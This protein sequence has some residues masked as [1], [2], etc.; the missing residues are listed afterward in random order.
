ME[1]NTIN[2]FFIFFFLGAI[3]FFYFNAERFFKSLKLAKP[4]NRTDHFWRRLWTTLKI[5]FG[6][7]RILR[8][9]N[10]GWLHVAIFW[11]FL[12][13]LFSASEALI[14]GFFPKFSWNFL[15]VF[16]S[17]ITLLT[18]IFAL[19]ILAAV[20]YAFWRRFGIKVKRLQGDKSEKIDATLVLGFIFIIVCS[21]LLQNTARSEYI[22]PPDYSIHPVSALLSSMIIFNP[23]QTF[24]YLFWFMHI[25]TI[26]IFANYLFYSKHFHVYTSIFNVFFG[27]ETIPNKLNPINFED[28]TIEQYGA[29]EFTDFTWKSLLDGY[30]CTHC[31]RC[32]SVCPAN[33]TGKILDPRRI[34]IGIRKRTDEL[35]PILI[36]QNESKNTN[37]T[38]LLPEEKSVL[39][40]KLIGDYISAEALWQCTTCGACMQECPLT[41]EHV[42]A[43]VEMRRNLVMME[44]EFPTQLQTTYD[45]MENAGNP[46][47]FAQADRADWAND[48]DIKIAADEPNFEYLYWVGCS[49]SYDDNAKKVTRAFAQ[50]LKAANIDF[51]ILGNE[52]MCNGDVARRSGNEYLANSLIN[53]NVETLKQYNVKKIITTCPHCYNTFKNEY[54][55]FGLQC[56]V[57]HHTQLINQLIKENKIILKNNNPENIKV[58]Y[59]DSCYLGRYNQ[60]YN[61]PREILTGIDNLDM[62][63][64]ERSKDKGFCCGAGGGQMFMEETEGKRINIARTEELTQSQPSLIALNCPFCNTMISDGIKSLQKEEIKVK[65]IAQIV[66][67][68]MDYDKYPN[69][70]FKL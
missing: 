47:G 9:K 43:I 36:K 58:A 63:E 24:Y 46:W 25:G 70:E 8:D 69:I 52:E 27:S 29:K 14:E 37:G 26:L 59:H 22:A 60:I 41:I 15:G 18:D 33:N 21:L 12:I 30:S 56:E 62:I 11:G 16:Y 7:T 35:A 23:P 10:A 39:D 31:G 64:T 48:L 6:Q 40:K 34:M 13:F 1:F 53:G 2:I 4:S 68:N 17:V 57:I 44:S 32:T 66:F 55:D 49:G 38:D 3:S 54:P 67:E 28:E 42:F 51:A 5:A 45:N 19:A 50:I 61:E 20:I 65:D